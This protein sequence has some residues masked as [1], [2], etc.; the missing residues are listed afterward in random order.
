MEKGRGRVGFDVGCESGGEFRFVSSLF[1]RRRGNES[2]PQD[3]FDVARFS[4]SGVSKLITLLLSYRLASQG[5]W[6]QANPSQGRTSKPIPVPLMEPLLM[7]LA[8]LSEIVRSL[9]CF[10]FLGFASRWEP[11]R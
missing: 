8:Y 1:A 11:L 9:S 6:K 7:T 5:Y 3:P 2:R 10:V 4:C